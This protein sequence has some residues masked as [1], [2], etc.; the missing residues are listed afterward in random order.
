MNTAA[1]PMFV[2]NAGIGGKDL[3]SLQATIRKRCCNQE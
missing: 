3:G 1:G 2:H